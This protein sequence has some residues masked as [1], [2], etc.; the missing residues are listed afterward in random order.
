MFQVNM[1]LNEYFRTFSLLMICLIL[2]DF[3]VLWLKSHDGCWKFVINSY[4]C[5]FFCCCSFLKDYV[6]DFV[7]A[8]KIKKNNTQKLKRSCWCVS[9]VSFVRLICDQL[10]MFVI[11]RSYF[12]NMLFIFSALVSLKKKFR[13]FFFSSVH[14][15][16]SFGLCSVERI[17]KQLRI[18]HVMTL[19]N[20]K[21]RIK[22]DRSSSRERGSVVSVAAVH[23]L[24]N[25]MESSTNNDSIDREEC[26]MKSYC[27]SINTKIR[28]CFVFS[29]V[30]Q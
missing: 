26:L 19:G 6:Y 20:Y 25:R 8:F 16:L 22:C 1:L 23:C 2:P 28:I 14:K 11:K 15:S 5:L 12:I 30:L 29:F 3:L 18:F 21:Y 4:L 9:S 7:F 27:I 24:N 10:F 17:I 13:V